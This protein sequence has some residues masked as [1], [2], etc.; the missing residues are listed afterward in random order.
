M[1]P[2]GILWWWSFFSNS[3]GVHYFSMQI[4]S[5]KSNKTWNTTLDKNLKIIAQNKLISAIFTKIAAGIQYYITEY[6]PATGESES[7]RFYLQCI[8][9]TCIYEANLC[10]SLKSSCLGICYALLNEN[11][12]DKKYAPL[13][14]ETL[15]LA[16]SFC[17]SACSVLGKALGRYRKVKEWTLHWGSLWPSWD[18]GPKKYNNARNMTRLLMSALGVWKLRAVGSEKA[19][20]KRLNLN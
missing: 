10:C 15:I 11:I 12:K 13:W 8:F 4:N 17:F 19:P 20:R 9:G 1:R 3:L 18:N 5:F 6:L 14:A 2:L 16:S 7:K